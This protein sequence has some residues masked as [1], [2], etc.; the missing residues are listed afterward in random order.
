MTRYVVVTGTDTGVGKTVTTAALAVALGAEGLRVAVVKLAQT[1]VVAGEPGDIDDVVRLT[2]SS[3]VHELAR[4]RDPLAPETAARLEGVSLPPVAEVADRI[5]RLDA[6]IVLV[7]GAGGLLVRLDLDGGTMIDL[8]RALDAEVVV[9]A[10]E[11]LGTLNHTELTVDRLRAEGLSPHLVVGS[12][13]PE[14]GLAERTNRTDLPRL[15]GLPIDGLIPAG[16]GAL[17]RA[18]FCRLAPGW[19]TALPTG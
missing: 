9:V 3:A 5:R 2:G 19:F 17:D 15:T 1:G 18:E 16:A 11:G 7:E 6:D 10:R 13:S 8:A 12:C 4:L 14:P